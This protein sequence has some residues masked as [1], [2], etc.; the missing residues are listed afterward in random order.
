GVAVVKRL[1]SEGANQPGTQQIS[2]MLM[3]RPDKLLVTEEAVDES[4]LADVTTKLHSL[5][6]TSRAL[7]PRVSLEAARSMLAEDR[8]VVRQV[9]VVT[10]FRAGDWSAQPAVADVIESLDG[11]DITVNLV[12]VVPDLH[13]NLAVT[14][15]LPK[16]ANPAVGVPVQFQIGVQNFG[17][18]VAR[19]VALSILVDGQRLPITVQFAKIEPG[20]EV[21]QTQDLTFDS[22]GQ[23]YVEVTMGADSVESDNARFATLNIV[24]SNPVLI[25]DGDPEGAAGRY[26]AAAIAADPKLTGYAPS[27]ELPRFLRTQPLDQYRCIYMLNVPALSEDGLDS[28]QKYVSGG[29]GLVW[30]V[31]GLVNA[32][33][34]SNELFADGR[35]LFPVRLGS[36]SV[37]YSDR[38]GADLVFGKHPVFDVFGLEELQFA[39]AIQLFRYLPVAE[40]WEKD[41]AKRGDRVSTIAT[42]SDGQ[43]FAFEHRY[44]DGQIYSFLTAVDRDW[45]NWPVGDA[46]PSFVIVNL[47]LQRVIAQTGSVDSSRAVGEP[48]E[49]KLPASKYRDAVELDLPERAGGQTLR[50]IAAPE[51]KVDGSVSTDL[52][53]AYR[54]TDVAGV[55]RVRLTDQDQQVEERW[56]SYN[57][58][59]S[60]S[61]LALADSDQLKEKL[62]SVDGLTIQEPGNTSWLRGR[63]AGQE[64][65]AWLLGLLLLLFVL[66]QL[67]AYKLSYHPKAAKGVAS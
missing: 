4:L 59:A 54:D 11:A 46:N 53:A 3:S 10:D 55:Y 26:V 60:E 8:A 62:S 47:D 37:P 1:L 21:T 30:F 31:G 6:C 14:Q 13:P 15:L 61:D 39:A 27:V 40:D 7:E 56:L 34:Y 24:D 41:D 16:G 25:V 22:A 45:T 50:M 58:S 64:I 35:G 36:A 5:K 38:D 48:I 52:F 67:L 2:I 9:H 20:T 57:V 49:L 19:D 43:P 29:G 51:K 63:D 28:L 33:F 18:R 44:G 17:E 23:H 66:E 65:R 32:E 12:R 42:L